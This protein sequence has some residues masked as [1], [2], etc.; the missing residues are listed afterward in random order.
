[1]LN[2]KLPNHCSVVVFRKAA[3]CDMIIN[4]ARMKHQLKN[5]VR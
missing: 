5:C 4:R 1:M 3:L 2:T